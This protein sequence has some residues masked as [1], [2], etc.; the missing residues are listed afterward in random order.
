MLSDFIGLVIGMAPFMGLLA[1]RQQIDRRQF[2]AAA[3]RADLHAGARRALAGESLPS[4]QVDAPTAWRPGQIKLS[5]PSGY[6]PLIGQVWCSVTDRLTGGYDVVI[7]C[8][9]AA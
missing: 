4:I 2:A 8:G 7:H 5:T 9:G 1:W 3:L 6:E